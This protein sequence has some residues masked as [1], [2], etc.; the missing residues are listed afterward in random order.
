MR[1]EEEAHVYTSSFYASPRVSDFPSC[2]GHVHRKGMYAATGSAVLKTTEMTYWSPLSTVENY[3]P[4]TSLR[5]PRLLRMMVSV[6]FL[7]QQQILLKESRT[8][9]WIQD[10]VLDHFFCT[11][12]TVHGRMYSHIISMCLQIGSIPSTVQCLTMLTHILPK[13][14][15]ATD[16]LH[17]RPHRKS[18]LE[19]FD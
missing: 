3:V 19:C 12:V 1:I 5:T 16:R 6:N 2:T 18:G 11:L 17:W 4:C 14:V 8:F 7:F 10:D 13:S 15:S 9:L